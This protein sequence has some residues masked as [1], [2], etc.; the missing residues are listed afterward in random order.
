MDELRAAL[1]KALA[2]TTLL[3]FK[4]H[5]FHWN[6]VGPSFPQYHEFLN[7]FYEEVYGAIDTL[8]EHIRALDDTAPY[9]LS[10]LISISSIAEETS[11]KPVAIEMFRTLM[12]DNQMTIISLM[13][14]YQKADAQTELGVSNFLQDRIAAHQ[15]HG[16]MLK[17]ILS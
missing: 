12:S 5:S 11:V 13:Q 9:S 16:W 15:K 1:L 8:A 2:D 7:E 4:S 14:A 10:Q 3:Y 6:I 17:A